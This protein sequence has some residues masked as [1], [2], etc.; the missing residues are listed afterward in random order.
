MIRIVFISPL[1]ETRLTNV[2]NPRLK[3]DRREKNG[4][5]LSMSLRLERFPFDSTINAHRESTSLNLSVMV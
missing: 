2:S 4:I 5:N 1:R 3:R